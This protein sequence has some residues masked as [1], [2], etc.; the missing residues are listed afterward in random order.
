MRRAQQQSA[1][2]RGWKITLGIG[3]V[4]VVWGGFVGWYKFFREVPQAPFANDDKRFMYGS[5]GAENDRGIP[6]WLW[7]VLPRMFPEYLPGPGGYKA[8]GMVWEPGEELPVG[9]TKKTVGFPRV[10]NNCA[11]CHTAQVRTAENAPVTFYPAG[12]SH[13]ANVQAYFR[14]LFAVAHDPRFNADSIMR[15]ISLVY[16]LPWFDRVLYRYAIIPFTKKAL[17]QQEKQFAWMNRKQIPDWGPGRDDPMNLTKYFMTEMA[18]DETTGNADFP[19]IWNLGVREGYALQFDGTTPSPRSVLIDSALGLGAR[20]GEPFLQQMADLEKYLKA[21][22]PPK[23]PYAIDRKLA[24]AGREVY[25]QQ[26]A[27]CHEVGRPQYGKIVDMKQLGTDRERLD[28]WT[29]AAADT[30]NAKVKSMGITRVNMIKTDGYVNAPLDGLWLRAP[31]LHNGSVPNLRELLE[32]SA[33]RSKMFYRGYDVYDPKNIGFIVQGE[34][35]QRVGWRYDTAVRGNGNDGHLYGT[36]LPS[37]K[38]SALLEY[39]KTL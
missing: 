30:A 15:E 21:L 17:L 4:L 38:K 18:Y 16:D 22:P 34:A 13:T 10:A 35:A 28:T 31:Y 20:P 9:F 14:F 25:E 33:R 36:Q 7:L 29:Q 1:H 8:L 32:P 12:P 26:C 3:L 5:L 27:V 24:L 2:G 37:A 6:Y 11:A 19:S 39:L 23:Y